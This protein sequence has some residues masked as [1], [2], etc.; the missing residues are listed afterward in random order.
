MVQRENE[1]FQCDVVIVGA[2]YAGLAAALEARRAGASVIVL[3]HRG[4]GNNS[5]L[6]GGAFALVNT[7]LQVEKGI[8]D[9]QELLAEDIL[10]ANADTVAKELD[11]A[12]AK[13][14]AELY[15]WLTAFGARFYE[16]TT[17]AGHSVPRVHLEAGLSGANALKLLLE[18][19]GSEGATI[20]LGTLAKH[21]VMNDTGGVMGVQ[22]VEDER[23]LEIIANRAVVVAAG[24]FGRNRE[25]M[26]KYLPEMA[27]LKALS[28]VGSSGDGIWMGIEAG[29]EALNMNAALVTSLACQKKGYRI[30]GE[31]LQK[32]GIFINKE[33]KRFVDES[34]GYGGS[35]LPLLRQPGSAALLVIDDEIRR[36]IPKMEKYI[37]QG[38]FFAG[39]TPLELAGKAG[40]EPQ[41][42]KATIN[43]YNEGENTR[44]RKDPFGHEIRR[45]PL[46]G[47]LYGTWVIPAVI[48]THGG[49]K[50]NN[51]GQVISREGR[52]IPHL[53]AAGDSTPG[54]GGSATKDC[55]CP[56]Y[57]TGCGYL[58]ALAS[59]R[60][61]GRNAALQV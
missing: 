1:N 29:A 48:Q 60:I 33:G 50:I 13:E 5:A 52:P 16:V 3:G 18:A 40:V 56:G 11:V 43:E 31:V 17:F 23:K 38:I 57:L 53:Y 6:G 61:A 22:A 45:P 58:W 24:G 7:P 10:K 8:K 20:R 51:K 47:T 59:G 37:E 27:G 35:F 9:S 39:Q 42:C 46:R 49:L 41:A 36:R 2:A 19:A 15:E 26:Q 55:P 21:L 4:I 30:S 14:G 44:V 54:L 34:I 28:G 12:A 32:G 25:M